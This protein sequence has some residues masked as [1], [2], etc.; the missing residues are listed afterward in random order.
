MVHNLPE[1]AQ[2]IEAQFTNA[3]LNTTLNIAGKR[4]NGYTEFT[5][6]PSIMMFPRDVI[7]YVSFVDAESGYTVLEIVIPMIS[8]AR[9]ADYIYTPEQIQGYTQLMS[10]LNEAILDAEE[11]EVRVNEA[12][13][14]AEEAAERA[15]AGGGSGGNTGGGSSLPA[16]GT[17]GQVLVKTKD[18]AEWQTLTPEKINALP[19]SY[20]P[21]DQTAE[22]VGADPVGT[23]SSLVASHNT[24]NEAHN[25]LR[26]ALKDLSERLD[27]FFDS[28]D[29]TLDEL[30]ELIEYIKNNK[31]LIDGIT[32]SKVSVSDIVDNLTTNLANRPLSAA[33]GVALKA[34]IDAIKIPTALSELSAD[35]SHL[36]VTDAEKTAW[37]AKSNF[38]GAYNDLTGKPTIPSSLSDL[39]QDST[40]RTVTD[41]EKEAWNT[42]SDFSGDYNDLK[43]KPEIPTVP[44][45]VSA[46]VNDAKYLTQHQDIS[47]KLDASKLPEA[48]NSALEQAK[49]SG[50]FD[51]K[52]GEPGQS[53]VYVGKEE[54]IDPDVNVWI[55]EDGEGE[56]ILDRIEELSEKITVVTDY[57]HITPG[58]ASEVAENILNDA[59]ATW[60]TGMYIYPSSGTTSN[61]AAYTASEYYFEIPDGGRVFARYKNNILAYPSIAFYDENKAYLSGAQ[62]ELSSLDERSEYNGMYGLFYTVPDGAKYFRASYNNNF[63]TNIEIYLISPVLIGASVSIPDLDIPVSSTAGKTVVCFGDS[64]FG[65][66]RGDDSAPAFIAKETGATVHNVGFGGCRMSVHPSTGYAAFSMWALAKAIAENNWTT[67]DAQASSGSDYFPTQLALLKSIDFNKVDI[68]V[69]HYGTN[70]FG[71]GN[72]IALDNASDPDDYNTLCGA[73]RYSLDKLLGKYPKLRIYIS[74]P[75]YRYWTTDGVNT[76]AETYVGKS[77]KTLPEFVEALRNTAAEYNL[78]VIDSYYGLGINKTNAS[79]FLSDGTHHNLAGRERFGRYIGANLIAQQTSGKSGVDMTVVRV[80]IDNSIGA[81]IGGA[82]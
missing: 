7:A 62:P 22:Q 27:A 19:S 43:N 64:L 54:P 26:L 72:A 8:R 6:P 17:E 48:I 76:Y 37:N 1:E 75:A 61:V 33:Q 35:A 39:T 36:L 4:N 47:G 71:A 65:M 82:Y 14:R 13:K 69:I 66:Y 12:V 81:A 57:V 31:T 23:A 5:I 29:K 74:L 70:D 15:E 45:N 53:G 52:D 56:D 2:T 30:S 32:T 9:P 50:E 60:T 41:A 44:T 67:Q 68:V 63:S 40:H 20:T 42:R 49:T 18:D 10:Q 16:G 51:G 34:L 77:G 28:D 11:L 55:D 25:D 59:D 80:L 21:P 3:K 58:M 78:P 46:F 38:S 24:N 73:L 79:A